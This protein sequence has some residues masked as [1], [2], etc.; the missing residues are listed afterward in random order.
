MHFIVA[1]TDYRCRH[2]DCY[3]SDINDVLVDA[4]SCRSACDGIPICQGYYIVF[5]HLIPAT[6][7]LKTTV[8]LS[9][10]LLTQPGRICDKGVLS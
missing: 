5:H 2:G 7:Y 1:A 10:N 3:G 8:C 6:C 9:P 4:Q